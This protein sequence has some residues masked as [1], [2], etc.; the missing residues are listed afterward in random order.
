M[1]FLCPVVSTAQVQRKTYHD[2]EKTSLHE[3]YYVRDTISNILEGP[4]RSYYLN[5]EPESRGQFSENEATGVWEFFYETGILKTRAQVK[6][7]QGNDG[8]Y[9]YFYENGEKSMEGYVE[10]QQQSGPWKFYFESGEIKEKGIFRKGIRDGA[11]VG[12]YED[13]LKAWETDYT[14][15]I[16]ERKDFYP[17]GKIKAQGKVKGKRKIGHWQYFDTSGTMQAEGNFSNDKRN[18]E[19]I[20]YH[21]NGEIASRGTYED[22]IAV[23]V[24]D[25]YDKGGN[26]T[27]RGSFTDGEKQ[28]NWQIFYPG[29][30]LKGNV[31]F[32][33]GSGPYREYYPSGALRANGYIEDGLS[34]GDWTY[35]YEDGPVEGKCTFDKGIGVYTGYYRNGVIQTRGTIEHGKRVGKWEL[36]DEE[37]EL[38][39][40][41]KPIYQDGKIINLPEPRVQR[42]ARE[43]GVA[44]YKFKGNRNGY[45]DGKLNEFYG[46]IVESNP[47]LSII[48][49]VPVSLE[50]YMEERLGYQ[51]NLQ[52][53][54]DPFFKDDGDIAL[55]ET[56]QRGYQVAVQQ[57]FYNPSEFGLWYFGHELR[58][59]SL[60]HY[61]RVELNPG[62]IDKITASEMRIN[63]MGL[64]GYRIMGNTNQPGFTIDTY[65]SAGIGYRNFSNPEIHAEVFEKLEQE[66][67][68]ARLGFGLTVGYVFPFKAVGRR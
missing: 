66:A 10:R 50:L 49:R 23:D 57:R 12:Y 42:P 47:L 56:F 45:F 38:T 53:I 58:F 18:G 32:E 68:D 11:W 62:E 7:G 46:L 40:Y 17:G 35:Y 37:G 19:W 44:D 65:F 13:G 9:E 2:P 34:Q 31:E 61:A 64:I 55:N 36:F 43:Y 21:A 6:T 14:E 5:G 15:G 30:T 26:I 16:G 29:G 20:F 67:F 4:Y 48:G 3:I 39:G 27:S 25:Y 1:G 8:Y 22:N 33:K 59:T 54:R 41:Y 28:G 24:W 51:L 60:Q 52:G 63:Y